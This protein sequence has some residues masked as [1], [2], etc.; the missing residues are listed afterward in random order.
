M[1]AAT[2]KWYEAMDKALGSS[3]RLI[4]SSRWQGPLLSLRRE[5]SISRCAV[6]RILLFI[7]MRFRSIIIIIIGSR[8]SRSL[9]YIHRLCSTAQQ[10][11]TSTAKGIWT[12]RA[13]RKIEQQLVFMTPKARSTTPLAFDSC[14]F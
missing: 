9:V 14:A 6:A 12:S 13:F 7:R 2:W 10:S 3:H 5:L 8:S 1:T 4:I 11:M